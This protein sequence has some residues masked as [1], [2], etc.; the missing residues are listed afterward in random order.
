MSKHYETIVTRAPWC[1]YINASSGGLRH[2]LRP[3]LED[4]VIDRRHVGQKNCTV[5]FL[6]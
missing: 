4:L 3:V 6:Q 2:G 1:K 5:L